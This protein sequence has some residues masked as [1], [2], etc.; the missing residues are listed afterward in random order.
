M[1]YSMDHQIKNHS[2]IRFHKKSLK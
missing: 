2:Q 1:S